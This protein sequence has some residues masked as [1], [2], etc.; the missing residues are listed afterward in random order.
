MPIRCTSKLLADI[1]DDT[2]ADSAAPTPSPSGDWYGHI[3]TADRRK[4]VLFINEPTLFVCPAFGVAK[5]DYRHIVPFFLDVLT[6]TLRTMMFSDNEVTWLV[7]LHTDLTI[8]PTVNGVQHGT[9]KKG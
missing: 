8:G 6:W 9:Q 4:C 2:L 1:D 5:S 3:F 7:S